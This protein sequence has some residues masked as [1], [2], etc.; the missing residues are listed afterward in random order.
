M[1]KAGCSEA[2]LYSRLGIPSVV[3]GPGK[4][5]GNIHQPNESISV[6]QLKRGIR[7]YQEFIRRVCF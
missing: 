7:F 2:G 1:A 3:I 4:A 6:K 5:T